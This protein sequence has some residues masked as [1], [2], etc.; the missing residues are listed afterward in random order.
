MIATDREIVFLAV[1]PLLESVIGR[2]SIN[3]LYDMGYKIHMVDMTRVI[4]SEVA[5]RINAKPLQDERY[6]LE[7]LSTYAEVDAFVS[8][9][10]EAYFFMLFDYY[11]EVR[12]I[13]DI[14]TK[15]DVDY[16]NVSTALT[17]S[18]FR[19][20]M[21]GGGLKSFDFSRLTPEKWKRIY[22][23]RFVRTHSPHKPANFMLV[24]GWNNCDQIWKNCNCKEGVTKQIYIRSFDYERFLHT[25]A[26]DNGGKPYAVFL[27]QFM[28]YHPDFKDYKKWHIHIPEKEYFEQVHEIFDVIRNVYGLEI[29]IAAHP[30]GSYEPYGD[31]WK[32]CKV[33]YGKSAELAKNASLVMTH[34]SNAITFAAMADKPAMLLNI[35]LWD[36]NDHFTNS[37]RLWGEMLGAPVVRYAK[38]MHE[39]FD[40]KVDEEKYNEFRHNFTQ[41]RDA[42]DTRSFW[43][44]AMSEIDE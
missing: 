5:D 8:A 3:E 7:L 33:L 41:S 25:D 30:R 6:P 24:G 19:P 16:G 28:P 27:D 44:I 15:Y 31:V 40:Y 38:D 35:P 10:Q 22:F 1:T 36:Q 17:D 9:H 42:G 12:K 37:C 43:E 20:E 29:I 18:G 23:N 14:L 13:Y 32:G 11:Y 4:D 2:Y 21:Y 39:T 34:F 26:Y